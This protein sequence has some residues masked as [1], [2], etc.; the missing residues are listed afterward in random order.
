MIKN[1]KGYI[2]KTCNYLGGITLDQLAT[3]LEE[4]SAKVS[5]WRYGDAIP[6]NEDIA[7]IKAL[8]SRRRKGERYFGAMPVKRDLDPKA[9]YFANEEK[10]YIKELLKARF[11]KASAKERKF[12]ER[13]WNKI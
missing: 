1:T 5:A 13:V 6:S 8:K 9:T 3:L 12:I 7:K 10:D 2:V 11:D 4:D